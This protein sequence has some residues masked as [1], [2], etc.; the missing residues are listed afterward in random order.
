MRLRP[1]QEGVIMAY[2][3]VLIVRT[4]K[5]TGNEGIDRKNA[6]DYTSCVY[7]IEELAKQNES[8]EWLGRGVIR[9]QLNGSL[10]GLSDAVRKIGSLPYTYTISPEETQ[11]HEVKGE[12]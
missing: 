2:S 9:L 12:G 6:S 1:E 8:L 3:M 11:W 5:I 7:E 4:P 10:K